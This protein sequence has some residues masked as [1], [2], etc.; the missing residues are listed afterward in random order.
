MRNPH[1]QLPAN[2]RIAILTLR[3][4]SSIDQLQTSPVFAFC[5][6]L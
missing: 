1:N 3:M 5:T 4:S 6:L 2:P